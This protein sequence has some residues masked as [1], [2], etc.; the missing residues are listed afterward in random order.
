M[1]FIARDNL[2]YPEMIY[3]FFPPIF[4]EPDL[5]FAAKFLAYVQ[6]FIF[7]LGTAPMFFLLL[8]VRDLVGVQSQVPFIFLC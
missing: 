5:S 7:A 1:M 8:M 2:I 6:V 4:G 3:C